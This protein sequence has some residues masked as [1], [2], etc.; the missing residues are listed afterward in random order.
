[1]CI[2]GKRSG[3]RRGRGA[4]SKTP[5]ISAVSRRE[6]GEHIHMRMS[7]IKAFNLSVASSWSQ[8]HLSEDAVAISDSFS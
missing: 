5:F 7:K 2:G 1:M 4:P 6:E 8:K 3:G